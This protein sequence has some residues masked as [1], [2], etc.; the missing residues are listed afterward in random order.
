[1]SNYFNPQMTLNS[2]MDAAA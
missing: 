2:M 1:M